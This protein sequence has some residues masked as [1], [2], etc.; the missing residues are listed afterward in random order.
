MCV[1]AWEK[2]LRFAPI[3][4]IYFKLYFVHVCVCMCTKYI[5]EHAGQKEASDGLELE[6]QAIVCCH[7]VLESLA[8]A[9]SPLSSWLIPP[10]PLSYSQR[11]S[12]GQ[13]PS[14]LWT[15]ESAPGRSMQQSKENIKQ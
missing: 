3:L 4:N 15:I 10:A 2:P 12:G 6:L 14:L 13:A 8:R 7:K 9:G 5:H 1:F 11:D